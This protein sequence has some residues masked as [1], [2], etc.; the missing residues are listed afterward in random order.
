VNS[1]YF[2]PLVILPTLIDGPGA[3]LTRCGEVV[4]IHLASNQHRFACHGVYPNGVA[5]SWHRSGRLFA[6]RETTNDIVTRA[7]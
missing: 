1:A 7:S 6:G 3:Y 5:D 4:E 2:A